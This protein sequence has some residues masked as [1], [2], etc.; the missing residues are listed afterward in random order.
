VH[1]DFVLQSAAGE[2]HTVVHEDFTSI[3]GT[4]VT[5]ISLILQ[6]N[7]IPKDLQNYQISDLADEGSKTEVI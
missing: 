4:N 2:N 3:N 7:E 6:S 5:K 1:E